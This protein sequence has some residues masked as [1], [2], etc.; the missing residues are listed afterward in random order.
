MVRDDILKEYN[1]EF[2][3]I[4]NNKEK[5]DNLSKVCL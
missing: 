4:E 1:C 5:T 2:V 3:D